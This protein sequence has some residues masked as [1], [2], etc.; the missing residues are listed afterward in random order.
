[1][2]VSRELSRYRLHL[3]GV[4]EVGWDGSGAVSA[5]EYTFSMERGMRT[6]NLVQGFMYI[7]ESY[8]QLRM[9]MCLQ[10]PTPFKKVGEV[11]FVVIEFA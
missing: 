2:T 9:A 5:R 6:M 7:R 11:L 1:M 3:V 8:Q 4:Q 10:I